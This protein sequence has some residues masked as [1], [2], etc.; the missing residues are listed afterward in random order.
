MVFHCD[1]SNSLSDRTQRNC[2]KLVRALSAMNACRGQLQSRVLNCQAMAVLGPQ[3]YFP[4]EKVQEHLTEPPGKV[5]TR[6]WCVLY[7]PR[8]HPIDLDPVPNPWPMV[9]RPKV[10]VAKYGVVVIYPYPALNAL[11]SPWVEPDCSGESELDYNLYNL[12]RKVHSHPS[13]GIHVSA[14]CTI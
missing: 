7:N 3:H 8:D 14:H 12:S 2:V 1:H 4:E 5:N 9:T 10:C 11:E 13:L 6:G